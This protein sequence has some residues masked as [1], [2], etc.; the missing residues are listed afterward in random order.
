MLILDDVFTAGTAIREAAQG[1]VAAGG[2]IVGV[3]LILD[4]EEVGKEGET[5]SAKIALQKELGAQVYAVLGVTDIIAWLEKSGKTEEV[6]LM[7]EY[8]ERYGIKGQ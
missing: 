5:E 1:I 8:R 4:R 7:K 2:T 6:A 3:V